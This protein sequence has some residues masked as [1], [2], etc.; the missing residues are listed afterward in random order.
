LVRNRTLAQGGGVCF[1]DV[2]GDGLVDIFLART[3]GPN[4]LYRNRGGWKFVDIAQG[5]GV[6]A[7]DRYSTGCAFADVDGDGDLDLILTALGG[8]N[9]LFLNDGTGHFTEQRADAGLTSSAGSTTIALADVD[10]GRQLT[11]EPEYFGLA[12]MFVD[13]NGDGAP[14]LYVAND[15]EDPDEFW[16]NDGRGHFRLAPWNAVRSTSNS[17]M[18][19][20]VGDVDRDGRPD[21]FEVDM[22]SRD[23]RRLKTQI[24]THTAVPKR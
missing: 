12:A 24:P 23:T 4:A 15:F 2:D 18:A 22:L 21:L 13:L 8:P 5:A 17:G 1:G 10:R 16:L 3:E 19:V 11:E 9:A 14:D 6:A 7:P 20:D